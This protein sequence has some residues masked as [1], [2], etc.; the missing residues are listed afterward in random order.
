VAQCA[1]GELQTTCEEDLFA[2]RQQLGD[3]ELKANHEQE[4]EQA[5]LT[6]RVN[7]RLRDND[8]QANGTDEHTTQKVAKQD[9]LSQQ[10]HQ[11]RQGAGA[12]HAESNCPHNARAMATV[13]V[14]AAVFVV[15]MIQRGRNENVNQNADC[16]G[17][18]QDL[19]WP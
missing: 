1:R 11:V 17:I 2:Q 7:L 9:G 5:K 14:V 19:D 13:L 8:S 4:E 16:D 6:D 18:D 15:A 3:V 12:D 10:V